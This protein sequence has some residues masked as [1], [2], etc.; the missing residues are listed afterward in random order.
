MRFCAF[1]NATKQRDET[2]FHSSVYTE[3]ALGA[4]D[5]TLQAMTLAKMRLIKILARSCQWLDRL[6]TRV[7]SE[8]QWRG[9]SRNRLAAL[10]YSFD[11]SLYTKTGYIFNVNTLIVLYCLLLLA[12]ST[13]A[14]ASDNPDLSL[15]NRIFSE[16]HI[17]DI[18]AQPLNSALT[19]FGAVIDREILF[20]TSLISHLRSQAV[21]GSFSV[22]EAANILLADS[23]LIIMVTQ[24]G[25][26]TVTKKMQDVAESLSIFDASTYEYIGLVQQAVVRAL[27]SSAETR[28]GH[29][30][31]VFELWLNTSGVVEQGRLLGSTGSVSRDAAINA[32]LANLTLARAPLQIKQPLTIVI[33]PR[34]PKDSGDCSQ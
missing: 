17:F 27:C 19:A 1:K 6:G 10:G 8:L 12:I 7:R 9:L 25:V 32:I 16:R 33:L 21:Q 14:H 5:Y 18:P 22:S 34:D 2:R 23:G 15:Q 11:A 24:G 20:E 28:P 3:S 26:L 4:P 29:Y 13:L 30:R 31:A